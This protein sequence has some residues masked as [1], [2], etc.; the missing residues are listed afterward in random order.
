MRERWR[1]TVAAAAIAVSGA[2]AVAAATGPLADRDDLTPKDGG[3]VAAVTAPASS[4]TAPE[5]FEAMPAGAATVQKIINRDIF[6]HPSA[7]LS[8]EEREKFSVGN[9]LFRKD[10]VTAPS[11]TQASDGLGPLFNARSCQGCHLKDGRGHPPL[12]PEDDAVS[13]LIRLSVPP[14]SVE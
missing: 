1:L 3:R 12:N 10:W 4:F 13:M 8:F 2:V 5:T 9:G 6:S 11:S 7:N 14:G